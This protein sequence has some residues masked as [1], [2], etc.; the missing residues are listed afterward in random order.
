MKKILIGALTAVSLFGAGA[1]HAAGDAIELPDKS[2]SFEGIFGNFDRPT[3][4]RGF[5]IYSEVCASCH[6]LSLVA[7]RNLAEIGMTGPEI[8]EYA[9]EFEVEDGP[10]DEGEMYFRPARLADK[11]V[12][13]FANDQAAR[14]SNGGAYPP[15]LS[16]MVKARKNGADYLYALMAGYEDEA[17]DGVE[18]GDGMYYN[19]YFPGHQIAM[20]PPLSED[21]V[22]YADGTEASVEQMSEDITVFLAWTASPELEDRKRL[23]LKVLLF[24]LVLTGMLFALK[25]QIWA[26]LH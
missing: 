9:S 12:P 24:L 18:L 13:P 21:L 17:P 2:W 10:D 7:Y 19:A 8:E 25:R 4:K 26:K 22:E 6:G 11:F 16:L 20:P 15:D 1:A 3:L 23:G 5:Q 14:A